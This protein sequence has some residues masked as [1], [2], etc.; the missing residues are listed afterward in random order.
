[1]KIAFVVQRYGKEVMGGSEL[2][3]R[4]IAESLVDRG[5]DCTVFTTT[6]KDYITW[7]NEYP[8][9]ETILNGVAIKRY[10]VKKRRDIKSFNKFS[11]WLFSHE[12]TPEDEIKWLEQQGP[13]SLD[14]IKA[15]DKE[16]KNHDIFIFFTYLYYNTYWGLKEVTAKKVL[17]PTAHNEPPLYLDL[18]KDVFSSPDAFMFNTESEK[19]MLSQVF[20]FENKYQDI[21]GVGVEIPE[22]LER[23]RFPKRFKVK[24]P[25]ILYA[26]R[27]EEGKGCRELV[28]YFLRYSQRVPQLSL[29]FIGKLLMELPVHPRIKYLGFLSPVEKNEAMASA[30]VTIHSSYYESLCMAA[31]ESMAVR[32]PLLVQEETEPLKQHC[33][34]GKSGLY[35][36]NYGEFEA[37]LDLFLSDSSLREVMGNN[38]LY[39]VIEHYSWSTVIEK[40][41]KLFEYITSS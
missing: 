31:L 41:R 35:Y 33:I 16:S 18:M 23:P 6:A 13:C 22:K 1:M 2:H 29:V 20:S 37:A 7:K 28:N 32:T 4:Q 30:L 36:S 39:Y 40:Y 17:V 9:G 38:G 8:P 12:H 27:I 34:M 24:L 21:V 11:D 10:R 5:Y 15:L 3:C 26:G 14:L 19:K 25:F